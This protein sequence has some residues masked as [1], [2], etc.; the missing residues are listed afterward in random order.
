MFSSEMN[1]IVFLV[2]FLNP[3]KRTINR[4]TYK[5][6]LLKRITH[7]INLV[8]SLK[9]TNLSAQGWGI[10]FAFFRPKGGALSFFFAQPPS[11]CT[12]KM[13]IYQCPG[14]VP[15]GGTVAAGID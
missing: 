2:F 5:Y 11:I 7:V 15:E 6:K 8:H 3:Q 9:L 13:K 12:K 1:T 14:V 10:C 4:R